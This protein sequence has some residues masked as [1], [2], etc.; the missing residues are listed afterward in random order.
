MLVGLYA[1]P[2]HQTIITCQVYAV[3]CDIFLCAS[4]HMSACN[5]IMIGTDLRGFTLSATQRRL[6]KYRLKPGPNSRISKILY[7]VYLS[8][9]STLSLL[10]HFLSLFPILPQNDIAR[11]EATYIMNTDNQYIVPTSG[12]PLRFVCV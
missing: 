5:F 6:S 10:L 1:L 11:A 3:D 12:N 2:T 9:F 7:T 4:P 8:F